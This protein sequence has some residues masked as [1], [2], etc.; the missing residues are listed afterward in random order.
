MARD[1]QALHHMAG[2]IIK[3]DEPPQ[4]RGLRG[5]HSKATVPQAKDAVDS[6]TIMHTQTAG[7]A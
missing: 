1:D 2:T 6:V 3:V 5:L 4:A 7:L